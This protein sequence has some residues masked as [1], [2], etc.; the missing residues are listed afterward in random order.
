MLSLISRARSVSMEL[1]TAVAARDERNGRSQKRKKTHAKAR[2]AGVVI[3]NGVRVV[4]KRK[5]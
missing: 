2:H 5:T 3:I 4:G 1:V